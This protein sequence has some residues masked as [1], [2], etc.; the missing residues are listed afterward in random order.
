MRTTGETIQKSHL[1]VAES[2]SRME[3]NRLVWL[4]EVV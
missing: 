3:D 1:D 2:Y 4:N